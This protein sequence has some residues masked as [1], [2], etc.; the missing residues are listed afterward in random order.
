MDKKLWEVQYLSTPSI[1]KYCKKCRKKMTFICSGQFRVNAQR[2]SLDVWLIYK[3]SNCDTT[4]NASIYSR[5]SPQTIN[6]N[7]LDGF[8]KNDES[9][10]VQYA[11]NSDFLRRNGVEVGV[12]SYSVIGDSF[13]VNE[14]I[15]LKI[16]SKYQFDIKVSAL[17]RE[18]LH[19]SQK[20]YTQLVV[21][22]KIKSIPDCDLQ[23]CKLKNEII[24]I[25][26]GKETR[27]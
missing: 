8:Y 21:N 17:V 20:E 16:K 9:L 23:K 5:V 4:W 3:C 19:L 15:E 22:G 18:K 27:E 6:P 14:T 10:A 26:N 24:L 12:P 7:L 13:S 11:M 1:L 25:F 2:R